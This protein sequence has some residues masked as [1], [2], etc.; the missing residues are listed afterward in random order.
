MVRLGRTRRML[1]QPVLLFI[2]EGLAWRKEQKSPPSTGAGPG[3]GTATFLR[4]ELGKGTKLP[5]QQ[6]RGVGAAVGARTCHGAGAG[7]SAAF[8]GPA[9]ALAAE[10]HGGREREGEAEGKSA[11]A[12]CKGQQEGGTTGGRRGGRRGT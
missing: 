8:M 7:N 3:T 10:S 1:P 5:L 12:F 9:L 2:R 4:G 11:L 6:Q